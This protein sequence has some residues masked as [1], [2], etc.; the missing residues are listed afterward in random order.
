[1]N[2]N[3]FERLHV[4]YQKRAYTIFRKEFRRLLSEIK[5]EDL[6][7]DYPE[8]VIALSINDESL[9][10]ALKKVYLDIGLKYGKHVVND[11]QKFINKETKARKPYPLFSEAFMRMINQFMS[12]RGGKKVVRL[13]KT[14]TDKVVNQ[15]KKAQ[16][17]GESIDEMVKR[18]KKEVNKSNFYRYEAMRIARTESLFA[19]NSA[20]QLSFENTDLVMMKVWIHGGSSNPRDGH[21]RMDGVKVAE[22]DY[23]VMPNGERMKYPGDMS[24]SAS[25]VI[26]C[27]CT[28]GY[29]ALRDRNGN[30]VFKS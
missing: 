3:N 12:N 21:L 5:F 6:N 28:F 14:M 29:E 9:T 18:I 1:M 30:V 2:K 8:A 23:F 13:T 19:M 17:Q 22:N 10:K 20:K 11:I 25:Q 4:H 27:S 15:I 24:A 7:Y 26:N 16:E